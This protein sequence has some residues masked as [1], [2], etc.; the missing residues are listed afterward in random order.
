L[1]T[2][3]RRFQF[4]LAVLSGALL[5]LSFPRY[6]HPAIAWVALVPL[7][8]ALSGW[9]GL[10][11]RTPGQPP[12]RAF[13][14]GLTAGAV[15]FAGTVYWTGTVVEQFG[16]LAKPVALFGMM[17]LAVYLAIYPAIASLL[18][19]R[20]I[21]RVGWR[22][23]VLAPA[24]WVVMEYARG[25]YL[26]G[27]FPWIPLG[28]SQVTVLPVAQLASVAGVYGL[29]ALVAL[30]SA[31][32][33][34]AVVVE[35][36]ART[37]SI[38][39]ATGLLLVCAGFGAWRV[40]EG[41]LTRGGTPI[42]VGLVQG[43]IPQEQ[44]W[45]PQF[46]REILSTHLEMTRESVARGAAF[47]LWPESSTPFMFDEDRAQGDE[48]RRLA[49]ELRVPV[50]LGSDQI[51]RK[52]TLHLYNSAFLVDPAGRTA[53]VYRKMHLVPFGEYIP[54]KRWLHFVSP[55]VESLAE[56]APGASVVMLPIGSHRVSTAICY[57]I[58]FPSLMRDAVMAGSELLT[59]I[60]NDGW[61]GDSS[62]PFQHFE[63]ASMRA[64]E[65]GRYL[66]RAANTG[67]SGIVDPYGRVIAR[68][69]IFER[70]ALVGEVRFLTSRTIY[71]IAGDVV[72]Y[73]SVALTLAALFVTVR[74]PAL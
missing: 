65:Q 69:S 35:G 16:G 39:A 25:Q 59:T 56:F 33:A 9:H 71:S 51:E 61:Y 3:P 1:S 62:A 60:T 72:V 29:S 11:A 36:R 45:D 64:I 55:L 22:G 49:Q 38:A 4:A 21:A 17:M 70:T 47:V 48:V 20:F 42:T 43:N 32:F 31:A 15:Y 2:S 7:L 68:S 58:V 34:V 66:A 53:G 63:L 10:P 67:I 27:G 41:S 40:A 52:P 6:G 50:L 37:A 28:S 14:L 12:L 73:A 74:R 24:P 54:F 30:V 44:K 18:T 57:E 19:S 23:I 46:Q 5:A 8:V 13:L 26:F